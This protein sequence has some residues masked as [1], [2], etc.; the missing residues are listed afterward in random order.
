[1]EHVETLKKDLVSHASSGKNMSESGAVCVMERRLYMGNYEWGKAVRDKQ[2]VVTRRFW[3]DAYHRCALKC[4]DMGVTMF[5]C[6]W[7]TDDRWGEVDLLVRPYR[8]K[9]KDMPLS[10][11]RMEGDMVSTTLKD[12]HT[13]GKA[14]SF[15]TKKIQEVGGYKNFLECTVSVIHFSLV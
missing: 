5:L 2:K 9:V 14:K 4:Y 3:V 11:I 13:T 10:H 8:E 1:M 15:F 6:G 7:K 12:F